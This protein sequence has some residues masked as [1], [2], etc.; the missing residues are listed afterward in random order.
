M[1]WWVETP[2]WPVPCGHVPIPHPRVMPCRAVPCP[3]LPPLLPR[4]RSDSSGESGSVSSSDSGKEGG[5]GKGV[6]MGELP[7]FLAAAEGPEDD[8]SEVP[9]SAVV[10]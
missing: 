2:V 7:L 3:P 9:P 6:S 5:E 1:G 8:L 10:R 4:T